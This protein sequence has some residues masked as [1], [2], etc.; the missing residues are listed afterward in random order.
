MKGLYFQLFIW[1][2][3]S[4]SYQVFEQYEYHKPIVILD[5]GHGGKDSGAIGINGL[6]E[7]EAVFNIAREVIR[8]NR[9][10]FNDTL[11]VY[12]TRYSDTLISL[13]DRTKLAKALKADVFVSIH[14]NQAVRKE[15]QGVEIYINPQE[16]QSAA[17]AELFAKGLNENLGFK[18]RGV[19]YENFQV[20][21]GT[22]YCTSVLLELGFL[23][24]LEEANHNAKKTSET[25]YAFLIIETILKY[26]SND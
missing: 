14:C 24:N 16:K 7:K 26:H 12:L 13:R 21:R 18:N 22:N 1:F 23:S 19:K 15:A 3:F 5:P 20:L 2:S 4:S 17:L 9:Q 25:A 11:E 6:K 10:L 8:L